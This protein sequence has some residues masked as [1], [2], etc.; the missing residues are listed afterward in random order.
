MSIERRGLVTLERLPIVL[1]AMLCAALAVLWWLAPG[2]PLD[3]ASAQASAAEFSAALARQRRILWPL[4]VSTS[5]ATLIVLMRYGSLRTRRGRLQLAAVGALLASGVLSSVLTE[6]TNAR[7]VQLLGAGTRDA[8]LPLFHR[9]GVAYALH[10]AF[11]LAALVCLVVAKRQPLLETSDVAGSLSTH[12]RTLLL[13]L[14]TATLFQGYDT[15]IVSMALPYIGR[16]LGAS[17][18]R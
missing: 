18:G 16:D 6:P 10:L 3:A 1:A 17:E 9:L 14:G 2:A 11:S 15:F 5:V 7:I 4:G 8:A 13:L 12:H